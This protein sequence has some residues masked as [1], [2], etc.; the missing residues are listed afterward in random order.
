MSRA[1]AQFEL[2]LDQAR[3][4]VGLAVAIDANTSDVLDTSD[5][6][7]SAIVATVSALDHYVHEVVRELM[8]ATAVGQR[9]ATDAFRRFEVSTDA[10][11][12]AARGD[13]PQKW[14]DEEVRRQHGHLSF[15]Q[16]EKVADA[17]RLVWDKPLWPTLASVLGKP[18]QALKAELQ[19]VVTRRNQIAHEADRDPTPP[20][21]RW[22][23]C[24]SDVASAIRLIHSIVTTLDAA[25]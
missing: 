19:V 18:A 14:M 24:S 10:A 12:A 8:V 9:P 17:I 7:R 11:L 22:P 4:L 2:N 20:N 16:P 3:D 23:I 25:L 6:L 5:V 15:Q 21:E 13:P 1:L